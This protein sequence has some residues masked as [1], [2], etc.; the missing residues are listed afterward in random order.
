LKRIARKLR[1]LFIFL[2]R[3]E[4][5]LYVLTPLVLP[6]TQRL[7]GGVLFLNQVLMVV[8]LRVLCALLGMSRP[9]SWVA[10]PA[11]S[12]GVLALRRSGWAKL[13]VY[14]C[15]DNIPFASG[16]DTNFIQTLHT[17]LQ[18]QADL[19]LFSGRR[20]L[21]ESARPDASTHLLSHG[22]DFEHFAR[23]QHPADSVPEDLRNV[24]APIVGYI[25]EIRELDTELIGEI[26][27][28]NP[29]VSFVFLGNVMMDMTPLAKLGN[30]HF[31]GRKAYEAL[32]A[33]LSCFRCCAIFY[34][35]GMTFN[36][37]RSPK[38][39]LEYF[40]TGQPLV[41]T[42]LAELDGFPDLIYQS[43]TAQTFNRQLQRALRESDPELRRRR[44]E[45]AS[46]RDWRVVA[47]EASQHISRQLALNASKGLPSPQ[48]PQSSS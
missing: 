48:M 2:R 31:L 34:R 9:I 43:S 17:R 7:R 42:A 14:Y 12:G 36:D 20:M 24:R 30:I 39:L 8:Q 10:T 3:A 29:D 27:L 13:L 1:S 35:A 47:A 32:P 19:V 4:P 6:L 15:V 11:V 37:Y 22:V 21:K 23:A 26:A 40:A 18:A 45:V 5:R 28:S 41:S 46:S 38:K 44:I 16:A 25:G 33:Y